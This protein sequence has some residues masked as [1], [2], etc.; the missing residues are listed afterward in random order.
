[1]CHD[2]APKLINRITYKIIRFRGTIEM[3]QNT[4]WKFASFFSKKCYLATFLISMAISISS[5]QRFPRAVGNANDVAGMMENRW[6]PMQEC[7]GENIGKP[8][9]SFQIERAGYCLAYDASH[10]NPAWVYEH[11]TAE[12]LAGGVE[13]SDFDFKEDKDIPEILR[14]SLADYKKQGFDRGHMAPAAN[15]R[16][17]PEAMSDTFYLSNMCPQSPQLNRGYWSKLEKHIRSCLKNYQNAYIVTGPLYLPYND[18]D[19]KRYVK[20]QVIGKNDIAV[21]THFFKVITLEDRRGNLATE[22]YILPNQAIPANTELSTFKTSIE[23]VEKL[24]G[25]IIRNQ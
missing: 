20:Y 16:S 15:H 12:D 22:A 24:A 8:V 14:A 23:K 2:F 10:R 4:P 11:L 3:M 13:R 9:S 25:F 5:C 21:P 6:L 18:K 17:S 19:G 1:M 7:T